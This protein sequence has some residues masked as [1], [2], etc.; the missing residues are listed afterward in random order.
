[1][2]GASA[3]SDGELLAIL[4]G[5]GGAG[6]D[7]FALSQKV[8]K[9]ID[10]GPEGLSPEELIKIRGIGRA[11]AA[12]LGAMCEFA[13]RRI[14]PEGQKIRCAKD[15]LPLVHHLSDR[16]QEHFLQIS[17]NGAHEV[18]KTR[19]VTVGL[20]N[21]AQ[22]HPREVFY[23]AISDCAAAVIVA[24]NHP[25]GET[26]PSQ[27]DL[28]VTRKLRGAAATLAI[29][30]LDHIIFSHRGYYSFLENGQMQS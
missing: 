12:L 30:L 6:Q 28:Q 1:M 15:I 13:R 14:R 21:A 17:L 7:V 19:V 27:E 9:F 3:L 22:V 2:H 11:K 26:T 24:H 5:S 23:G 16:K 29:P 8:L 4:L 25:S 20:A 10:A 18:I